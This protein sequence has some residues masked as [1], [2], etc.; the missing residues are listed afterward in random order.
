[1]H[2]I[3]VVL[4]SD[5]PG[6]LAPYEHGR[7]VVEFFQADPG[8]RLPDMTGTSWA[9]VDWL[10]RAL[11]GLELCRRLRCDPRTNQARITMVLEE[12]DAGVRR[13]AINAGADDCL[14]GPIDRAVLLERLTGRAV[15]GLEES[16]P[17]PGD[18]QHDGLVFDASAVQ[19]RWRGKPIPVM[20]AQLRLLRFFMEHPGK[21]YTRAQL[22]D[23][24]GH[25]APRVE[26]TIDVWVGRLRSALRSAGVRDPLRTVHSL[27]YMFD[28]PSPR[29][30]RERMERRPAKLVAQG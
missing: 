26:R 3:N 1:M 7:Q 15:P 19:L 13:R 16:V 9:L 20:P 29:Q 5:L 8:G 12:D 23:E 17:A 24:L 4:F 2:K 28:H 11:S 21:I 22:M 27:G 6:G 18:L 25:D 14:V 30:R 10:P